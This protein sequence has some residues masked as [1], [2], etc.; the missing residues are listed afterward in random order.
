MEIQNKTGT[1]KVG[2]KFKAQKKQ[3]GEKSLTMPE[4]IEGGPFEK[5]S[6]KSLEN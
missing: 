6:R 3:K 1:S 2:A 5:K 4:R